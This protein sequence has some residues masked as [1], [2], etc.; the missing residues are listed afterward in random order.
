MGERTRAPRRRGGGRRFAAAAALAAVVLGGLAVPAHAAGPAAPVTAA[1]VL[2]D[3]TGDGRADLLST[4]GADLAVL[5][6]GGAPYPASTAAQSPLGGSWQEYQVSSRGSATGTKTDDLYAFTNASDALYLYPNDA[7]SGGRPG[8]FTKKDKAVKVAKP[9]TCA[10]GADCTG[11]DPTW[12]SAT[13]VLAT[14]GIANK[15]GMPDLV[16]VEGGRLWY[17]PGKAGGAVI[18]A[19]VQLGGTGAW[20][21]LA[22]MAPGKVDGVPTL[23][24]EV[25][26]QRVTVSYPLE[27]GPDGLP[28]RRL[29]PPDAA[30]RLQSGQPAPDGTWR[31]LYDTGLESCEDT[32]GE[33][34]RGSDG[35]LRRMDYCLTAALDIGKVRTAACTG[36]AAQKW[37][38]VAD[39]LVASDGRC[40]AN[41]ADRTV[42]LAPCAQSPR[43]SWGSGP[44]T[45]AGP[46]PLPAAVDLLTVPAPVSFDPGYV[47]VPLDYRTQGD[48]DG[49]GRPELITRH[50]RYT[51]G[52]T[53][54]VVHKGVAPAGGLARFGEAT[55]VG[56][57]QQPVRRVNGHGLVNAD[58][59]Y[60]ACVSLKV[61]SDGSAVV[62]QLATGKVLWSSNTP[63]HPLGSL[64]MEGTGRLALARHY[65]DPYWSP[66]GVAVGGSG[67]VLSVQDDCNVVLRDGKGAVLWSTRTYDPARELLGTAVPAGTR[68]ANGQEVVAGQVL[69]KMA[70][71][72]NLNL[73]DRQTSRVLWTSGNTPFLPAPPDAGVD[74]ALQPDGNLVIRNKDGNPVWSSG[75]W[76]TQGARL[77]VQSDGNLV[78]Y[79][80]DGRPVWSTGTWFGGV[81]TLGHPLCSGCLLIPYETVE[82]KAGRLVM[83]QDGNLVLYSKATGNARWSSGT[84]GHPGATAFMQGD[85]NLVVRASD[86][87]ALW[88]SGTWGRGNA[89]AVLQDDLN[90][91]VYDPAGRALWATGTDNRVAARRGTALFAGA[92]VKSGEEVHT[93]IT[94]PIWLQMQSDGNLVLHFNPVGAVWSSRTWG[95]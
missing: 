67:T 68:L 78:I 85:G 75:T 40:L 45:P 29:S 60:S 21:G 4:G 34:L 42:G 94:S 10:A 17:Y 66:P 80:A 71:S 39:S 9:A 35:T 5:P 37:T 88:A 24:A 92:V 36:E 73:I 54:V 91:V 87:T 22:L 41:Q 51:Y 46:E 50:S 90:L 65:D 20:G 77:V 23:W 33:W 11:Y 62:T 18:G 47:S 1:G 38:S 49:D 31:C 89:R 58:V 70:T 26:S 6:A 83:Q 13:Q 16:T 82:S 84:W 69:L 93:P 57:I 30:F 19:P 55:S 12:N 86:G 8:Y 64:T 25:A 76:G 15:D 53:L 7:N 63:G 43:Q 28:V 3:L 95:N 74:G 48:L 61:Q 2:N 79:D 72:G 14:D 59:L 32:D 44:Q 52:G 81:D 56:D 27:F